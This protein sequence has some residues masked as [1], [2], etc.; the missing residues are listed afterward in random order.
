VTH[1]STW[2]NTTPGVS[3]G[4]LLVDLRAV[5]ELQYLSARCNCVCDHTVLTPK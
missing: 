2:R 3:V 4:C 1:G 5:R